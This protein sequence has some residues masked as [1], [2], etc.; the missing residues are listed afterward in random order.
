MMVKISLQ[1]ITSSAKLI[2]ML[3]IMLFTF[4]VKAQTVTIG[5]ATTNSYFNP[6]Y[7]FYGYNYTQQIYKTAEITA[8]GG[9]SGR[10]ITDI[11]FYWAG[12]GNLTNANVWTVY[13]GNTA[14]ATFASTSAWIP[15]ASMSQV[16]SGTV[17]LPGAAG[18]VTITLTNPIVWT[19]SNLVVA[20]DENVASYGTTA[21]WNYSVVSNTCLYYYSDA[22]NPDPAA[23]P[24]G[25]RTG[26]RPNIQLIMQAIP[27]CSG[28]PNPGTTIATPSAVTSG[29]TTVLSLQNS[30]PGTGV[31][32]VWQSSPNNTTWTAITGATSST[33]TAT[34]TAGTYYRCLVTCTGATGTSTPVLV[35]LVYCTPS[36][37]TSS[38]YYIN[39]FS[40]T[41]GITNISNTTT[42]S[43][44]GYGNFTAQSVSQYSGSSVN[45]SVLTSN[46]SYTYGIGIWVDWNNDLDFLDA[47]ENVYN[48]AAFLSSASGSFSVPAGTSVG[49]YRM[50][51]IANYNATTPTSCVAASSGNGEAEDYTITVVAA[52]ACTGTPTP[53]NTVTSSASVASGATV[54]LSLSTPPTGTGLT[55]QWQSGASNTGPWTNVGTSAATYTSAAITATTWYQCI[56]T[57]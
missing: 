4:N 3:I 17:T 24:V 10:Q 31:T 9:V 49:N 47:G 52:T 37:S 1:K 23:P 14:T 8:G 53:G 22:T 38:T 45:F 18:W 48:S 16:Y 13:I 36:G 2:A 42:Y 27:A 29:G 43:A 54:N 12:T 34:V 6:L 28:T 56:V 51:V 15:L 46:G 5:T 50:R 39:S 40:T 30:T 19:G 33:Y 25:T 11:K 57:C 35:S 32:Y 21:Y 55:Y 26:N 44:G 41:S 20:V 7:T